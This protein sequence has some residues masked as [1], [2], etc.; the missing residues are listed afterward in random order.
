[1]GEDVVVVL[2]AILVPVDMMNQKVSPL[3]GTPISRVQTH[4]YQEECWDEEVAC[5]MSFMVSLAVSWSHVTW[6]T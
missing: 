2:A 3:D 4:S 5:W 6:L 1:M